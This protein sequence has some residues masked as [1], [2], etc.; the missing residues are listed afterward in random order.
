MKW[1]APT[2]AMIKRGRCS[3]MPRRQKRWI[4][5][6]YVF[7]I[8]AFIGWIGFSLLNIKE[9]HKNSVSAVAPTPEMEVRHMVKGSKLFLEF[10]LKHFGLHAEKTDGKPVYGEG[11]IQLYI[12]GNKIA[13]IHKGAYVYPSLTPGKHTVLV[14]LAHH[15]NKTYGIKQEFTIE[16]SARNNDKNLGE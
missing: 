2:K 5:M 14:E 15:D 8:F 6:A 4:R 13:K 11:H 3:Q 7:F 9:G 10:Q 12:D 1:R 16:V